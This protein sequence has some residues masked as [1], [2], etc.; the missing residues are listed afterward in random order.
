[1]IKIIV[2]V[3]S[4][5]VFDLFVFVLISDMMMNKHGCQLIYHGDYLRAIGEIARQL[6]LA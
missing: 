4:D 6:S 2:T 1:M 5:A 3:V